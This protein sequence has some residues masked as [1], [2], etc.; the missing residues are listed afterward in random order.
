MSSETPPKSNVSFLRAEHKTSKNPQGLQS[1][2]GSA[3]VSQ[4][5]QQVMAIFKNLILPN[6][7]QASNRSS[8]SPLSGGPFNSARSGPTPPPGAVRHLHKD[9]EDDR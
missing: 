9:D 4:I 8:A 6:K 7:P 2:T 5:F 3:M 1:Q